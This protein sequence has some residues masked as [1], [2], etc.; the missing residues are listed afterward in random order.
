[1]DGVDENTLRASTDWLERATE[2]VTTAVVTVSDSEDL[3]TQTPYPGYEAN[4]K[5][6][7]LG[8]GILPHGPIVCF[9]CFF[10]LGLTI[11]FFFFCGFLFGYTPSTCPNEVNLYR[12]V[13]LKNAILIPDPRRGNLFNADVDM[14]LFQ[15]SVRVDVPHGCQGSRAGDTATVVHV[16]HD[17]KNFRDLVKISSNFGIVWLHLRPRIH[18]SI[19]H[20]FCLS[21]DYAA[22]VAVMSSQ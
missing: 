12:F 20:S 11:V 22:A 8:G 4:D 1:M 9:V 14:V 2:N 3:S 19:T 17:M 21:L 16:L 13:M 7:S 6:S 10:P 15:I 5:R 18:H